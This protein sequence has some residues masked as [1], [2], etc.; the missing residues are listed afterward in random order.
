MN[1]KV[2]IAEDDYFYRFALAGVLR[3]WNYEVIEAS[4]GNKAWEILQSEEAP[5]IAILDWM[6]PGLDGLELC[7]RVR[8]LIRP[9]PTYLI[10]LTSL[11][12]KGNVV[13]ALNEGADDFIHKPFDREELRARLKVGERIV[14]LQTSQAVI[15]TFAR[16]V[17][18]KCAFT[19][20][21]ADRVAYYALALAS[22]LELSVTEKET[23]RRG[24]ILHDVG[25]I[26]IPDAL[27]VKPGPLTAEEFDLVKK[28]PA[29]GAEIIRPLQTLQDVVPLV[30]WHHE[31]MDGAG[32]P[33]R[34][35]GDQ[36]PQLVRILSIADVYDA[37]RSERPYR[38]AMPHEQCLRI[39][40]RNGVEGGVDL[41]LAALFCN[42][43]G[44]IFQDSSTRPELA[45]LRLSVEGLLLQD[46]A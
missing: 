16:A 19:Q 14:G 32:Y 27:L 11:E 3:E 4:D 18:A 5:K 26:S 17:E 46:C 37:L 43:P 34:I 23:L 33:D 45:G 8:G 12:G 29:Q 15:F 10:I 7:R 13:Q 2:L 28:H 31:R 1:C 20:G 9:E 21:H 24:A 39:L 40:L 6:M 38:A 30:R 25:K 42:L 41:D 22:A 35:P 44:F 36:I